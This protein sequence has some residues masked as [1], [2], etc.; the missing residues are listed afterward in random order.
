MIYTGSIYQRLNSKPCLLTLSLYHAAQNN[1]MGYVM[2]EAR[3][4]GPGDKEELI[5]LR[6]RYWIYCLQ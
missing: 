3:R 1:G 4:H 5:R 2:D 6:R